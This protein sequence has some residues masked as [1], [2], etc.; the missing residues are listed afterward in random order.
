MLY[1]AIF[2]CFSVAFEIE[3]DKMLKTLPDKENDRQRKVYHL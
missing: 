3:W 1:A 2:H